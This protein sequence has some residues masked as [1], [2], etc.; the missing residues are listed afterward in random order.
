MNKKEKIIGLCAIIVV[1]F[2]AAFYLF[3]NHEGEH[4]IK[5]NERLYD[6]AIEYLKEDEYQNNNP[7]TEKEGYHFFASYDGLGIT[8]K[9]EYKYVYMWVLG[10]SY[11]LEGGS[12]KSGSAF[13]MLFK[14]KF[15]G[16]EIIEMNIPKDGSFY[17]ESVKEMCP[18]KKMANKVLEYNLKFD[19]NKE[20][21][22]YYNKITDSTKLEKNDI[23]GDNQLLFTISHQ[24]SKC[25]SVSLTVYDNGK[26]ELY[27]AYEACKDDEVCD[28]ILKYTKKTTGEYD[29]DVMNIIKNSINADYTTFT[30]RPEYEINTGKNKF[31]G[32]MVTDSNNKYLK[33]FLNS[34][35]VDLHTCASLDYVK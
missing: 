35:N 7:D 33:E 19:N 34:I 5:D 29:Y 11:Y 31:V 3:F 20:I 24:T 10:E 32:R 22:E 25:V 2:F 13:S 16:D 21:E 8:E 6:L 17:T 4:Y 12:P 14:F 15:K 26:Y 23:I 30:E 18:D 27:T 1:I 9:D 28:L